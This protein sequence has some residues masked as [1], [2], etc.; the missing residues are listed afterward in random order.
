MFDVFAVCLYVIV[1]IPA[2][3]HESKHHWTVKIPNISPDTN[4]KS[5]NIAVCS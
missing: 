2:D 1:A 5:E 3:I 4:D